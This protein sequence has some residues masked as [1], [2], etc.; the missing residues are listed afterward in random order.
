MSYR[1]GIVGS[2]FGGRVHAP[3]YSL[4]PLYDAVAIAS[5]NKAASVAAE[6]NIPHAFSSLQAMLDDMGSEIDVISIASPPFQHYDDVMIALAAG[7]HVVCEKPV[8]IALAQVEEMTS[9]AAKA[10]VAAAVM[11]EYRYGAAVQVLRRMISSGEMPQL[12]AIEVTR[13]GT[14]LRRETKRPNT[15]W[16][17]R[18][19]K[20]GGLANAF[21]PHI[22]D[23]ALWLCGDVVHS[24]SGFLRTANPQRTAPDGS[25]YSSD[26]ADGCYAVAE[27]A[28]GVA[29]RMT[30]D[31][32][33]PIDHSTV[34]IYAEGVRAVAS[35]AA[36][37]DLDVLMVDGKDERLTPLK[38]AAHAKVFPTVPHVMALLDDFADLLAG[39][40]SSVPTFA[41]GVAVQ[42]VLNAIGYET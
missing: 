19:T 38:Y 23:L 15:G 4:H 28:N 8:G 17:F 39:K 29:A 26:V 40:P 20:G 16:W 30:V 11:F 32:T 3:A 7:K 14:E 21:M 5:P 27:L 37:T 13:F 24:A 42:R 33:V 41:D 1:V 31:A 25:T 34:A 2:G 18:K 10:G 12:R 9:A 22:V 6:R 36:L 35:G